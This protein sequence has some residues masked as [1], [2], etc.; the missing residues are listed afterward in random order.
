[1]EV[2][3]NKNK[4]KK[5]MVAWCNQYGYTKFREGRELKDSPQGR[6]KRKAACFQHPGPWYSNQA[7]GSKRL[8]GH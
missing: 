5:D 6:K 7:R 1:M 8:Q 3:P 4:R 2:R